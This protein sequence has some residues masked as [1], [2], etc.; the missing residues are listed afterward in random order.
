MRTLFATL[1]VRSAPGIF[2]RNQAGHGQTILQNV[3]SLTD[4]PLNEVTEA[5]QPGQAAILWG[6]GLGPVAADDSGAQDAVVLSTGLFK[7]SRGTEVR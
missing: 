6:T 5:A 4:W 1:M 3:V 7:D 2:T